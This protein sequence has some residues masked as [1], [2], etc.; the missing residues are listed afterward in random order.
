V[1]I[2]HKIHNKYKPRIIK[3]EY[4]ASD[5]EEMPREVLKAVDFNE[6]ILPIICNVGKL[7]YF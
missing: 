4:N 2:Q 5:N 6:Y 3:L 1:S 7:F